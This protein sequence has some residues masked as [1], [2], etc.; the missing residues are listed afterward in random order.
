[1]PEVAASAGKRV[2]VVDDDADNRRVLSLV[3]ERGGAEVMAAG[4]GAEALHK[5]GDFRPDLVVLDLAM[6]E[7]DGW[8]MVRRIKA[9]PG[10]SS[11]PIVVLTAHTLLGEEERARTA[12]C[13]D[14]ITKP[15]RPAEIRQRLRPWLG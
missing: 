9:T 3:L 13:D 11:I 1:M 15:C 5:L 10:L 2:L 8:E 6:P 12:G 4:D 14:Y 7:V